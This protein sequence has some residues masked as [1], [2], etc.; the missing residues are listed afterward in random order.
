MGSKAYLYCKEVEVLE[1]RAKEGTVR[2]RMKDNG[3]I[4]EVPARIVFV[5]ES[6]E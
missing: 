3:N 2:V 4:Y 6:Q 5:K 1:Y